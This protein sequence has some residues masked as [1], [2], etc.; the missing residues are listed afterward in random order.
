MLLD[1]GNAERREHR[2]ASECEDMERTRS[3]KGSARR[4]LPGRMRAEDLP[5]IHWEGETP[6]DPNGTNGIFRSYEAAVHCCDRAVSDERPCVG[7]G[8]AGRAC[9]FAGGEDVRHSGDDRSH[10]VA[11]CSGAKGLPLQRTT[12]TGFWPVFR[13]IFDGP[14]DEMPAGVCSTRDTE[15]GGGDTHAY[16]V[17]P[18]TVLKTVA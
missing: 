11:E 13:R 7:T 16:P 12:A 10:E 5:R 3:G 9:D 8:G 6:Q 17:F 2:D 4:R 14:V 15:R 18:G 1:R